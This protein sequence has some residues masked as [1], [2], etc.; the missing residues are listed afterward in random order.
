M[1]ASSDRMTFRVLGTL[2]LAVLTGC[3]HAPPP[4]PRTPRELLRDKIA[5]FDD[6]A[7]EAMAEAQAEWVVSMRQALVGDD[8]LSQQERVRLA[9]ELWRD[10]QLLAPRVTWEDVGPVVKADAEAL[11]QPSQTPDALL[12]AAYWARDVKR[13]RRTA[14]RLACKST[15]GAAGKENYDGQILCGDLVFKLQRDV[16]TAVQCW[17]AAYQAAHSRGEQCEA[18]DRV[19]LN[20]LVPEKDVAEMSP[21]VLRQCRQYRERREAQE[22]YREGL[23]REGDSKLAA[24]PSAAPAAPPQAAPTPR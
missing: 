23:R 1:L 11:A 6:K 24:P 9:L 16:I 7:L 2:V 17:Q 10:R 3:V 18:V 8:G 22:L 5:A 15:S 12:L 14:L 4:S 13:D 21:E 20:S 19:E